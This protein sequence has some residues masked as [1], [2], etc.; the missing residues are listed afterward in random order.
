MQGM[1][2]GLRLWTSKNG[3]AQQDY[4]EGKHHIIQQH[5]SYSKQNTGPYFI[6]MIFEFLLHFHQVG[7]WVL[8][9]ASWRS[10][11]AHSV[12]GGHAVVDGQGLSRVMTV[13]ISVLSLFCSPSFAVWHCCVYILYIKRVLNAQAETGSAI[14]MYQCRLCCYQCSYM[15]LLCA[16]PFNTWESR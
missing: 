3:H 6:F 12:V 9:T 1:S 10:I 7:G 4:R 15:P 13:Y 2:T 14:E 8:R 16:G 5:L 11:C